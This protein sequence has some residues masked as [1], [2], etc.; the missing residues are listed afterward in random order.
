M[1]KN[2]LNQLRGWW[3]VECLLSWIER[4]EEGKSHLFK[5]VP[6]FERGFFVCIFLWRCMFV[7]IGTICEE[8]SGI[9]E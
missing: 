7:P 9:N 2:S 6:V 5:V 4:L 1:N 8:E 3:D